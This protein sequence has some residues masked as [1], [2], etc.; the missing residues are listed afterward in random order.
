MSGQLFA[1]ILAGLTMSSPGS[2]TLTVQA[3]AGAQLTLKWGPITVQVQAGPQIAWDPVNGR[4]GQLATSP[5]I[6]PTVSPPSD[7]FGPG[8]GS[9]LPAP[10]TIGIRG[11]F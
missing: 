11:T 9:P 5:A 2:G 10:I 6:G 8:A 4:Q 3:A 7:T 1:Q